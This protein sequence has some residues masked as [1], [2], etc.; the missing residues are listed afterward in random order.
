MDDYLGREC[1]MHLI[2]KN[3]KHTLVRKHGGKR[4][5]GTSKRRIKMD[6]E[7]KLVREGINRFQLAKNMFR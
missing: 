7:E 6:P 4:L 2:D 3:C 1:S 5:R